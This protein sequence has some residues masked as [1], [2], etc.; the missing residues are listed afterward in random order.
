VES[1]GFAGVWSPRVFPSGRS[2]NLPPFPCGGSAAVRF[3]TARMS[4]AFQ[5]VVCAVIVPDPL[6]NLEPAR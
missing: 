4:T 5:I 3:N 1:H 6:Q 2:V